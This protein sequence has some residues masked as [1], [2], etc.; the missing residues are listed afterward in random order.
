MHILIPA[1][2]SAHVLVVGDLMLD[3]YWY[4]S[5]ARI[6][7]EAPVPVVRVENTEERPGGAGN[8][9][10]NVAALGS[11]ATV[12]GLTGTDEAAGILEQRLTAA[13]VSCLFQRHKE[14]STVTK[15]RVMSRHQQLIR[16]DFEDGF[17]DS[18]IV[19]LRSEFERVL[20]EADVVV[21]SDYGK[22]ALRQARDLIAIARAAGKPVLV[23][24]KSRD[25]SHYHGA[26]LIT[27]NLAEFEAVVGPCG[28]ERD[29]VYKG[30]QL[31]RTHGFGAILVTRG[32]HGM[33]LVRDGANELHLPA[34][35]LEVYDVTGAG[36]TVISVLAACLA[37]G[38]DLESATALAN[39]AA[40]ISV[41]KL[42][43]AT[44]SVPE[45]RRALQSG[46]EPRRGV[47]SQEQLR[48][49][50]DDAR[51]HG[52]SIVMTNGCFDIL[53]AGHVAYLEQAKQLGNRLVVAVNDDDSV[54]RL[55]GE[56]RPVNALER[57]MAV[58]AGLAAVDWVV[59]FSED[60][61]EKLICGIGPDVLVKGGDYR[62]QD[63]AGYGCVTS[64]GGKVCILR[65]E[66]GCSTSNIIAAIRGN[67]D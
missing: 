10:L 8:V 13:G 2:E 15:L 59:P 24:P 9:A 67:G 44:V 46:Q 66:D 11:R 63:V 22:G 29:I 31:L 16:L 42:G 33:T 61:P 4:G 30:Q 12:I 45:L 6:S 43:A 7:P 50:V 5:T 37:T 17:T 51:A 54:R 23:D 38:T 60:T 57:R 53:H 58:L 19:S 65:Y 52:E 56:G 1:F 35:A 32:E 26:S 18:G 27:P 49:A 47:M 25:F 28:S 3:R 14:Y 40:G 64:R 34:Q 20:P 39:A 48:V 21:L 55:K 36:D 62:A 41:A